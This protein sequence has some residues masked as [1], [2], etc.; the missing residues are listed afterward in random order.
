MDGAEKKSKGGLIALI[1]VILLVG[2]FVAALAFNMGGIRDS[3][4]GYLG[5][6]PLVGSFF[7]TTE[8]GGEEQ[9]PLLAMSEEQLRKEVVD[10]RNRIERV[11]HEKKASD[12]EVK[13]RDERIAHLNTFYT[14]WNEYENASN[15]FAE[16]LAH[17]APINFVEYF[18][19]IVKHELVPQDILSQL[20]G[21]ALVINA[22]DEELG[23]LVSTYKNMEEKNAAEVLTR[24]RT[25][26][27]ELAVRILRALN[28][29][30]RA[31]IFDEMDVSTATAFTISLSIDPPTFA[32]LTTPIVLPRI[33]ED[34]VVTPPP[35]TESAEDDEEDDTEE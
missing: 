15:N 11:E 9:D 14:R 19:E 25:A 16:M 20:Y 32:P 31:L 5:R 2:M 17:N 8:D 18:E 22:F 28:T 1:I 7:A 10:L 24:L 23:L 29:E 13:K 35:A 3:I 27:N 6:M 26:N 4:S 12:D 33:S 21:Q 34:M 30:A